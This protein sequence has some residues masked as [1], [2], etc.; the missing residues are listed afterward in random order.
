MGGVHRLVGESRRG[1]ANQRDVI[2]ELHGVARG[3]LDA[4]IGE[5]SDHDHMRDALLFQQHVEVG[6][7]ESACPQ[8]SCATRSPGFVAKSGAIRRAKLWRFMIDCWL[9]LG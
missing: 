5:Q 4:G 2:A 9:G 6:V 3:G 8:C 1:V 7:G